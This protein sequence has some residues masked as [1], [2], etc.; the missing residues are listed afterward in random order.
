MKKSVLYFSLLLALFSRNVLADDGA[1][2][3]T[4]QK[5]GIKVESIKPSP[6]VGLNTIVTEQGIIYLSDDGK[7]LLQGPIYDVSGSSP[8]NVSNQLLMKKLEAMKDQMII[9]KA[10]EEKHVV[11][12]FTDITCGY[13]HKLHENMQEYNKLGITVRY[14]AFPRQGMQNKFAEEMQSIWCSATPQKSLD[15]AFKGNDISPIKGC[16]VD[17]ANHYK[18]GLQFGVQ[19]TPAIILKDGNLLGGYMPP[20]ALAKALD[21]RGK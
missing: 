5:L 16:K 10:P 21:Q 17:I 20:E 3:G 8:V 12:V 9:Y 14:L 7:Y 2:H 11:T 18:L 13:C 6:I 19:G 1:V 15:A 4:M